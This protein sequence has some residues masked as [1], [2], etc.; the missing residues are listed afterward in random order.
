MKLHL[1]EKLKKKDLDIVQLNQT[2]CDLEQKLTT[3]GKPHVCVSVYASMLMY[4]VRARLRTYVRT[5][6]HVHVSNHMHS[7]TLL[8]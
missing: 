7:E 4:T 5:Y 6:V 1:E 3:Y 2:N 8:I